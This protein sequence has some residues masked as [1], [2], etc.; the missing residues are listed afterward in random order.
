MPIERRFIK[1]EVRAKKAE[2]G[3][4]HIEGY[5][6]VFNQPTNIGGWFTE[7]IADGAFTQCLSEGADVRCLFNHDANWILGRSKANTLSL[8]EDKVGLHYECSPSDKSPIAQHVVAAV[9]R[10]DVDGAS[11]GFDVIDDTWEDKRDD[12]GHVV[13]SIRTIKSAMIYDC[14]PVVF[15]AYPTTSAKIRSLFPDGLPSEIRSRATHRADAKDSCMCPCPDCL[16]GDCA[17]CSDPDCDDENCRCVRLRKTGEV[18]E[19][20][21]KRV[22]GEDLAADCFLIVGDVADTSTWKLP[23][24]FSTDVKTKSH[25]RNALARWSQLKGVGQEDKDK[26]WKKLVALCKQYDIDVTEENSAPAAAEQTVKP[27][28]V[29]A[30]IP[31]EVLADYRRKAQAVLATI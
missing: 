16:D 30:S 31:N 25:L 21:T 18:R 9:D 13:E 23:F 24:K 12:K 5:G 10:G 29:D 26:A 11:F 15:P 2:D 19:K 4:P 28:P 27:P 14:G 1:A 3:T 6:A 8:S 20:K 22:D 17:Q 7:S